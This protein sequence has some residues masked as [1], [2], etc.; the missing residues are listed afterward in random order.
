MFFYECKPFDISFLKIFS[1]CTRT[2]RETFRYYVTCLVYVYA[3]FYMSHVHRKCTQKLSS[4][5]NHFE[6]L[7]FNS[8]RTFIYLSKKSIYYTYIH[9]EE[10]ICVY[11]LF[12]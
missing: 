6:M 3:L 1:T 10:Y 11:L 7:D 9:E 2:P 4:T 5:L 8:T 12:R